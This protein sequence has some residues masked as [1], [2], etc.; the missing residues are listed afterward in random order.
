MIIPMHY[1]ELS[2]PIGFF[3]KEHWFGVL[4][5]LVGFVCF[6]SGILASL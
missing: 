6:A 3:A 4:V 2:Q 5:L 1:H